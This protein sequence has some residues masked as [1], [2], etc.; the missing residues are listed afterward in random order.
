MARCRPSQSV[1]LPPESRTHESRLTAIKAKL[2]RRCS[3][4]HLWTRTRPD[5]KPNRAGKSPPVCASCKRDS[6]GMNWLMLNPESCQ[7]DA[8]TLFSRARAFLWRHW[9]DRKR[10]YLLL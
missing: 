1:A 6:H 5:E 8:V 4:V 2:V 7:T 10:A 3:G 9:Q